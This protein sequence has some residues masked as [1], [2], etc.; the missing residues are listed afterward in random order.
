MQSVFFAFAVLY[1]FVYRTMNFRIKLPYGVI[2]FNNYPF[3]DNA[4]SYLCF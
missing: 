1:R 2:V 4:I 3:T